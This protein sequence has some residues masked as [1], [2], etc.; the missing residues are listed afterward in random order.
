M[1]RRRKTEISEDQRKKFFQAIKT[2]NKLTRERD[3]L[4]FTLIYKY[5][6]KP[7][8]VAGNE[9]QQSKVP[10]IK[11]ADMVPE[12]NAVMI[13]KGPIADY[14]VFRLLVDTEDMKRLVAYQG[15]RT[16]GKLFHDATADTIN[17]FFHQYA[18]QANIRDATPEVLRSFY[19]PPEIERRHYR[20][21][22]EIDPDISDY[23]LDMADYFVLNFCIENTS[24]RIISETLEAKHGKGWWEKATIRDTV[25]DY[26]KSR[27]KEERDTTVELR[28]DDPLAYTT[29]GHLQE[30]ITDN[31]TEFEGKIRSQMSMSKVFKNLNDL[32]AVIA[33][34]SS[35]SV[36]EKT[37]FEL[38]VKDWRRIQSSS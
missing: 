32:R 14:K 11:I 30:I 3:H 1:T 18:N 4:I 31:W 37:R 17:Y 7:G 2:S 15:A 25:R 28:S 26:V 10:G 38:A 8:E 27:Q 29:L 5:G 20:Y 12:R 23:A 21:L 24:R 13:H 22:S 35:F 19:K 33:H 9:R 34:S 6:L 16:E 36:D